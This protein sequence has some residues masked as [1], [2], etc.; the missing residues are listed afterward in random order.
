MADGQSGGLFSP[1]TAYGTP[2]S[3]SPGGGSI[4]NAGAAIAGAGSAVKDLFGAYGSFIAAK[5]YSAAAAQADQNAVEAIVSSKLQEQMVGQQLAKTQGTAETNIAGGN[6]EIG[7]S[8]MDIIRM[9]AVQGARA[10]ALVNDQGL[11]NQKSYQEQAK[12]YRNEA[13]AAN[14]SGIG[15]ILA[16]A[17]TVA[18]MLV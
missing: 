18:I 12:A 3:A 5:N 2:Q 17:A 8:G 10:Q 9:N 7:G 14:M 11:I 4:F 15:G 13:S 1:D 16:A 6:L